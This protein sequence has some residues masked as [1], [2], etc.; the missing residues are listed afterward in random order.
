MFNKV[1]NRKD[2]IFLFLKAIFMGTA[3]KLPG[4]SGGLVALLTGF[5]HEMIESLKTLN[6]KSFVIILKGNF[7]K[8][9]S[10]HNGFFI[11][12]ILS[13]IIVSYFTTSKVLD[14]FFKQSELYVWSVFYGMIIASLIILIKNNKEWNLKSFIFLI[15]GFSIGFL[16]SI[17][18]PVDENQ[19]LFFVFFCGFI[20]VCGMIVPGI[21]GS[22]L[23]ILLG[24][25]KLLLIDSVNALFDSFYNLINLN[26]YFQH[27][28]N[29][30]QILLVF[31]LGSLIGL[32]FLSSL[33]SVLIKKYD[34]IINQL[35]IGFVTGSLLIVWPWK[36]IANN[37]D[38]YND[39]MVN[40]R[41]I[42]DYLKYLPDY[43][44]TSTYI[45]FLWIIIGLIIVLFLEKNVS[46]TKK[47]W[48]NR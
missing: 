21:S 36:I 9:N 48:I 17:L 5:Y 1:R 44:E 37:S 45:A 19:N 35:I 47:I 20:S 33:L 40:I 34:E 15:S 46:R 11:L 32:I 10:K 29:L 14:Y 18:N 39:S 22:F 26:S 16:L 25:Y 30:L 6:L 13:G 28:L 2:F 41:F 8:F 38:Y 24:N 12:T 23:L 4:I 31:A 27:D 3:N 7:T 42:N 43:T